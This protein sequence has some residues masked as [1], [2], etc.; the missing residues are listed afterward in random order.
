MANGFKAAGVSSNMPRVNTCL[1]FIPEVLVTP[2]DSTVMTFILVLT[3][4][5]M[6]SES[7]HYISILCLLLADKLLPKNEIVILLSGIG[8][9]AAH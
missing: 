1:V 7:N 5:N 6:T 2:L 4:L 9:G 3:F 8:H